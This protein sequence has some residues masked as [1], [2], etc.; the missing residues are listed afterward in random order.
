VAATARTTGGGVGV[1]VAAGRGGWRHVGGVSVRS[2]ATT[3]RVWMG[4]LRDA[5]LAVQ[6]TRGLKPVCQD[7]PRGRGERRGRDA[8]GPRGW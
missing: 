8:R 7:V 3:V 1:H 5:V 6:P 4:T 2:R